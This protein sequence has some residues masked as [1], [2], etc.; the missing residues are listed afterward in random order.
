MLKE[1]IG[2]ISS[3]TL[4]GESSKIINIITKDYGIIGVMAKGARKLK[5]EFRS[6]SD[7]LTYGKFNIYY[8]EDKLSTLKSVDI[9]DDFKNIKNNISRISYA[10]FLVELTDQVIKHS[11]NFNIFDLLINGLVKINNGFDEQA[12]TNIIELKYLDYLGVMPIIDRCA[13]CGSVNSISTI[14][15]SRGG[16][17]C[18]NCRNFEKLVSEKAIKLIRLFYYLDLSKIS[19]LDIGDVEKKEINDFL[20]EYYDKY[21]GLYLKSKT[22]LKNLDKIS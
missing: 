20:D 12:I 16:Y 3:V 4:Y 21:T 13:I 17:I 11:N 5:S 7:K 19:K 1:V 15:S 9:I 14:S 6:V 22:F 8:K 2:I 10:S 18:N